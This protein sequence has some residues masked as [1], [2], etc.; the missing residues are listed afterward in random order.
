MGDF[1]ETRD[2]ALGEKFCTTLKLFTEQFA[3]LQNAVVAYRTEHQ[4]DM[5]SWLSY[6]LLLV[7]LS[8]L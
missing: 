6:Y 4:A 5:V 2:G 8:R 3:L 1:N 7:K